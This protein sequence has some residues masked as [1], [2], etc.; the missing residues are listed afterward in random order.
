[1]P[2]GKAYGTGSND[3]FIPSKSPRKS[4]LAWSWGNETRRGK[5]GHCCCL[6]SYPLGGVNYWAAVLLVLSR[7]PPQSKATGA[8]SKRELNWSSHCL[9]QGTELSALGNVTLYFL[10]F[11]PASQL[12]LTDWMKTIGFAFLEINPQQ[13]SFD[14]Q[15]NLPSCLFLLTFPGLR[16][17]SEIQ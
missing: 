3:V 7:Q 13:I 5:G 15:L 6:L 17:W 10:G 16:N 9:A 2:I 8:T 4:T 14:Y 11:L 12:F 1:M